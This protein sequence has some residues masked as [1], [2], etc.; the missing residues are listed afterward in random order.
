MR[1]ALINEDVNQWLWHYVLGVDV[2]MYILYINA[3]S[4][5]GARTS[6]WETEH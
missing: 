3:E 6:K 2:Y 5:E 1:R 4:A